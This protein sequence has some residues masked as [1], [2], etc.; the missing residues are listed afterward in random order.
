MSAAID[1]FPD[2]VKQWILAE[3]GPAL[4]EKKPPLSDKFLRD[5]LAENGRANVDS[6]CV[7]S[8]Q[9]F[10]AENRVQAYIF[11]Y[12]AMH[13]CSIHELYKQT[14]RNE[15][16]DIFRGPYRPIIIDL[17][18]G[19]FTAGLALQWLLTDTAGGEPGRKYQ[20]ASYFGIDI[21]KTMLA[22]GKQA[23]LLFA[24]AF[25]WRHRFIQYP[26]Q[27]DWDNLDHRRPIIFILSFGWADKE[28]SLRKDFGVFGKYFRHFEG[29]RFFFFQNMD[30]SS[31]N[32]ET[33]EFFRSV[34]LEE[35]DTTRQL[36][37][38]FP[39]WDINDSRGEKPAEK[40]IPNRRIRYKAGFW[41][42]P[43]FIFV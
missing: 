17:G 16:I 8:G 34:G 29:E 26:H 23:S 38:A 40:L 14:Y 20:P 6:V 3:V 18:C 30:H 11:S 19:P 15:L 39:S 35:P 12:L 22:F 31:V 5:E 32:E 37:Y 10:T 36:Y 2:K 41:P 42:A 4:R 25:D 1:L 21:S 28:A 13:M 43:K 24:D 33:L 7:V 9:K 27:A